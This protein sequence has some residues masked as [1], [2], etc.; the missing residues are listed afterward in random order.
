[1]Q[2]NTETRGKTRAAI[3]RMIHADWEGIG[4]RAVTAGVKPG[5]R[6]PKNPRIL[7]S[8]LKVEKGEKQG[9]LTAVL[10]LPAA[11]TAYTNGRTTCPWATRECRAVC[12]VESGQLGMQFNGR[13]WKETLRRGAPGLFRALLE[14]DIRAHE[15]KAKRLGMIPA[16]RLD[17]TSDLGLAASYA[18]R[19]PGVQF[20]DY[21]KSVKRATAARPDNWHVTFSYAGKTRNH[22]EA[23]DVLRA[24]GNVA[25]V[26]A[27]RPPRGD[28]PGEPKP[29]HWEGFP[30]LD[31]DET[32]I[33]FDDPAGHVVGLSLKGNQTWEKRVRDAGIFAVKPNG[34][35]CRRLPRALPAV[36]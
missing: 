4:Q 26:F 28:Y 27:V 7:G 25:V 18:P 35:S 13:H 12:L 9:V 32:D 11:D 31:G 14:R 5:A 8:S 24:G 23:L 36:V 2:N 6:L 30:V 1:M 10:Y 34:A 29:S 17:G 20:Y 19:F 33:R 22:F 16:V 21:T 15:A 3:V